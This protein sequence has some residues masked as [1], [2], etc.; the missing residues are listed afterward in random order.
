MQHA[1]EALSRAG[2]TT[3]APRARTR[4]AE[5]GRIVKKK[6]MFNAGLQRIYE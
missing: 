4:R 2:R 6:F 1:S 5:G 3:G